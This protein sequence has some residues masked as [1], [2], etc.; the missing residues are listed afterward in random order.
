MKKLINFLLIL[1]LVLSLVACSPKKPETG[2]ETEG[3]K[4]EKV[5]FAVTG[6]DGLEE[7]EAEY[8]PFKDA[9]AEVLGFEVEFYA[10]TDNAS[11]VTALK[12]KEVDFVLAGGS[13]YVM[14]KD[15]L[16]SVYA[17]TAITRPGYIP[18]IITH[19]DSGIKSVKDINPEHIIGTRNVGSTSGHL[20][21]LKLLID[22]GLELDK[23]V[24]VSVIGNDNVESFLAREID[25]LPLTLLNYQA[26]R[27]SEEADYNIII[28]GDP[29]PNDLLIA[30]GHLDSSYIEGIRKSILENS[31]KLIAALLSVE[32]NEK[33]AESVFIEARDSEYDELRDAYKTLG[34][35]FE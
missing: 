4:L 16:D 12:E 6:I 25:L 28:Q 17:L 29:L 5:K 10:L 33:Y 26:L 22:A 14:I 23:D 24:K 8:G 20:M 11:A 9:L 21:P 30:G 27:V 2:G 32:G 35:D 34:I 15:S 13:D 31:D 1:V 18:V 19:K 7:L 3:K